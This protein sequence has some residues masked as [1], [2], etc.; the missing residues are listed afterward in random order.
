MLGRW[1]LYSFA[2]QS[3]L[4]IVSQAR[5]AAENQVHIVVG[6]CV[7]GRISVA[8]EE[9]AELQRQEGCL[10]ALMRVIISNYD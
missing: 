8:Q 9:T 4:N 6:F 3:F 5:Q 7:Y 1:K 2:T 10:C